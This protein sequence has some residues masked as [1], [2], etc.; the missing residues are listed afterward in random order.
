MVSGCSLLRVFFCKAEALH[1]CAATPVSCISQCIRRG[2]AAVQ[3]ENVFL[4]AALAGRDWR[5]VSSCAS[6]VG[7]FILAH[8]IERR[9][10][11]P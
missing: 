6:R 7:L 3:A 8:T 2:H 1:A 5:L 9:M 4:N 10:V 11:R